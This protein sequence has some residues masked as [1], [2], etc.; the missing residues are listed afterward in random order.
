M[1]TLDDLFPS[2]YLKASD[3]AEADLVV[4][5]KGIDQETMKNQEGKEEKKPV[6]FFK[7]VQK[8]IVLNQTNA[9]Q[10]AKLHG[11]DVDQWTGKKIALFS[12][13]VDAFGETKDAIRIRSKV[14]TGNGSAPQEEVWT[15]AQAVQKCQDVGIDEEALK[16]QLKEHG[17]T[18]YAGSRDTVL[19]KQLI[20][21]VLN[22]ENPL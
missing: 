7:E 16:F 20:D 3:V 5:I 8:G 18:S 17:L 12:M 10:I 19:V 13:E 22:A 2:K 6:L 21:M 15:Y 14:P 4:T 9:K 11:P 1:T